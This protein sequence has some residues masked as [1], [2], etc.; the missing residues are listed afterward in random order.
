MFQ[1]VRNTD[2]IIDIFIANGT[3]CAVNPNVCEHTC[4]NSNSSFYCTCKSGYRLASNG[5]T[6]DGKFHRL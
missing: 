4:H 5:R 6:C 3:G 1:S 2:T